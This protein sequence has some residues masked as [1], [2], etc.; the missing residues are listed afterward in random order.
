[1][2]AFKTNVLPSAESQRQKAERYHLEQIYVSE[3][4]V[5][6]IYRNNA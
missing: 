1:M 6:F 5:M 2:E 3:A 4:T